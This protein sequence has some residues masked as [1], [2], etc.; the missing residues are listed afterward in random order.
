VLVSSS[1]VP[2]ISDSFRFDLFKYGVH[3]RAYFVDNF[4]ALL[5][6]QTVPVEC[7]RE[8][9]AHRCGHPEHHNPLK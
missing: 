1:W 6:G 9:I 4:A 7:C 5:R 2:F 3:S 8:K